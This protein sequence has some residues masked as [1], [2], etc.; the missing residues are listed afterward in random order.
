[1]KG[2]GMLE[3]IFVNENFTNEMQLEMSKILLVFVEANRH[4]FSPKI[5]EAIEHLRQE[6]EAHEMQ[7]FIKKA[8]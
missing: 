4:L 7:K 8:N 3:L 1:M 5:L 2:L 6:I